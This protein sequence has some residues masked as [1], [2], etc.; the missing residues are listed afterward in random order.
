MHIEGTKDTPDILMDDSTL[1]VKIQGSSFSERAVSLYYM[2]MDWLKGHENF[3]SGQM[4]IHFDFNYINSSTKKMVFAMLSLINNMSL[5][6]KN[7]KIIWEYEDYDEDMFALG[8]DFAGMICTP[9]V[10]KEKS[11][12]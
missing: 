7:I 6:G 1:L 5:G 10:F 4:V 11:S 2:V 9:F 8:E 3:T 12:L